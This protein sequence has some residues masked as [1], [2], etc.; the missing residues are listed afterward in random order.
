VGGTTFDLT[1]TLPVV[2]DEALTLDY[3]AGLDDVLADA[4]GLALQSFAGLIVANNS[5]LT[6]PSPVS[7]EVGGVAADVIS[8]TFSEDINVVG[9]PSAWAVTASG[10]AASVVSTTATGLPAED[11]LQLDRAIA[12][13]ETVTLAYL[14][15]GADVVSTNGVP[16]NPFSGFPVTNNVP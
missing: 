13:G 11:Q 4:T 14:V 15:G 16:T 7:A 10:G 3:T 8:V 2:D 6:R 12:H 1:L 9:D 5:G